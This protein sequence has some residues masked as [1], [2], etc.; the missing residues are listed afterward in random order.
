MLQ[1]WEWAPGPLRITA[2]N[3]GEDEAPYASIGSQVPLLFLWRNP[4]VSSGLPI[5]TKITC[6]SRIW[7]F[8]KYEARGCF[9]Q[10]SDRSKPR[11]CPS[12]Y[13]LWCQ[14]QRLA[15]NLLPWGDRL[16]IW[17]RQLLEWLH[18][19]VLTQNV[20]H[21]VWLCLYIMYHVYFINMPPVV[22]PHTVLFYSNIYI[23]IPPRISSTSSH[24]RTGLQML[25]DFKYQ[26]WFSEV[27]TDCLN[28]KTSFSQSFCFR[29]G[30][31]QSN[32]ISTLSDQFTVFFD[33]LSR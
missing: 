2:G 15:Q 18:H 23:I 14:I 29:Y 10:R 22:S 25:K 31:L 1:L 5:R 7:V 24:C 17:Q 28:S 13:T 3:R 32:Q 21:F 26:D 11:N 19:V 8:S 16:W 9:C 6:S 27:L 20:L 30:C 4:K 33:G 12:H